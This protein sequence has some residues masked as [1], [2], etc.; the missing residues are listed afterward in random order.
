MQ[1]PAPPAYIYAECDRANRIAELAARHHAT[2]QLC[3]PHAND[4]ECQA[5]AMHAAALGSGDRLAAKIVVA[6]KAS[7]L[8][9]GPR[10]AEFDLIIVDETVDQHLYSVQP[11]VEADLVAWWSGMEQHRDLYPDHCPQRQLWN[12]LYLAAFAY[13]TSERQ[14]LLAALLAV[15]PDVAELLAVCAA[16]E[17]EQHRHGLP[18][19]QRHSALTADGHTEVIPL[20]YWRELVGELQ[21]L[22]TDPSTPNTLWLDTAAISCYRVNQSV[23]NLLTATE[24]SHRLNAIILDAT[25][26]PLLA[27]LLPHAERRHAGVK[28]HLQITQITDSLLTSRHLSARGGVEAKRLAQ[29]INALAG[30]CATTAVLGHKGLL[31]AGGAVEVELGDLRW[32]MDVGW[33]GRDETAHN[34]WTAVRRLVIA[35]H[36]QLPPTEVQARAA[37]LCRYAG[38]GKWKVESGEKIEV[39]EQQAEA[40][41]RVLRPY[42]YGDADGVGYGYWMRAYHDPLEQAIAL[43]SEQATI[44]Q[45]VGRVRGTLAEPGQ[46]VEVYLLTAT[47]V[48]DLQVDRLCSLDDII[49]EGGQ[50][51]A[52]TTRPANS[53]LAALNQQRHDQA[54]TKLD[55]AWADGNHQPGKLAAA[56]GCHPATIA[57]YIAQQSSNGGGITLDAEIAI[58]SLCAA[59]NIAPRTESVLVASWQPVGG[60]QPTEGY[61]ARE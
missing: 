52:P 30:E 5:Q 15:R 12:T 35:G 32:A 31:Q 46:P 6:T 57:S 4:H 37:M 60:G 25:P 11:I 23:I 48:A 45:A 28:Q 19:E 2:D 3:G 8:N 53:A 42:N 54:W 21:R 55:A 40:E 36:H 50:A 51:I 18:F 58:S 44:M 9:E 41:L 56:T 13:P 59:P 16:E 7:L 27:A 24:H 34:R 47:P 43:H 38:S 14:P 17:A 22:A 29:A 26:S 10:L 1:S 49:A 61:I 20:V 39:E 33:F